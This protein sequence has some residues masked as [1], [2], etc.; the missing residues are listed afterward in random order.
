MAINIINTIAG[1]LGLLQDAVDWQA[2]LGGDWT[3]RLFANNVTISDT[4]TI[5]SVTEASFAGYSAIV[6]TWSSPTLVGA[7]PTRVA[8]TVTWT[9]SGGSTTTV[10][11]LF[12]TDAA[13][14]VLLGAANFTA[15]VVLTVAQPS[16]SAQLNF[17]SQSQY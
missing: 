9:Y 6:P 8:S 7:V 10:Y 17:T 13:N 4:T 2:A 14:T 11:G 12:M 5:G 15:P 16:Y 3:L 1:A